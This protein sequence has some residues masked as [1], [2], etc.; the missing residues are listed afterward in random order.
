MHTLLLTARHDRL[1]NAPFKQKPISGYLDSR[2]RVLDLGCGTGLWLLDMA[3]RYR[4]TEFVGIDLAGMGPDTLL[5]NVEMRWPYDYESPWSLGEQSWDVIHLQMALG[6]VANWP[7]LYR[8]IM[9]HLRRGTGYFEQVEIDLTPRCDDGTLPEGALRVWY[10]HL[11][12]ATSTVNRSIA[13][14]PRVGDLLQQAGFVDIKE[15]KIILPLNGWPADQH[16]RRMGWWYNVAL[17]AGLK[18]DGCYGLEAMSLAPLTRIYQWP[19]D[20]VRRLCS[21]ALLQV[22]DPEVHAYHV[23]HIWTARSPYPDERR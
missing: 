9:D 1:L 15:E 3:R 7:M 16:A 8:R 13:Y 5:P 11:A 22:N 12:G 10:D 23:L 4:D 19:V 18:N 17:S 2:S 6:S 21:D 20:H 14:N